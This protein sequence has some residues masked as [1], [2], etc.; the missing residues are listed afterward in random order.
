MHACSDGINIDANIKGARVCACLRMRVCSAGVCVCVCVCSVRM[1]AHARVQCAC[2]CVHRMPCGLLHCVCMH[3]DG[4]NI[5]ANIKGA[6]VR[7]CVCACACVCTACH[8]DCCNAC[9]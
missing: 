6:R 9:A 1:C 4:M 5:D 3:A 7:M 8:A 2:V